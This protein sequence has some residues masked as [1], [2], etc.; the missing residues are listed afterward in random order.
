M[1]RQKTSDEKFKD[2]QKSYKERNTKYVE[3]LKEGFSKL[4]DFL[5]SDKKKKKED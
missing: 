5:K 3:N 1:Q 2:F 4:K